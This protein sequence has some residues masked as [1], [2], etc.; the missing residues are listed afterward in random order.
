MPFK[1]EI[2]VRGLKELH[3]RLKD[4]DAGMGREVTKVNKYAAN[5]LADEA[6]PRYPRR[7]GA[8]QRSVRARATG[9]AA[10]VAVGG[11]TAPY[12]GWIEFGGTIAPRGAPVHRT[13]VPTG[14][15]LYPT[16]ARQRA[17]IIE[18]YADALEDV[19]RRV[20]LT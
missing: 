3:R 16:L 17:R 11:K 20:D 2:E 19:L 8:L 7:S 9:T 13:R 18:G 4:A 14:R 5:L 12:A 10:R 6:R 1:P 15:V